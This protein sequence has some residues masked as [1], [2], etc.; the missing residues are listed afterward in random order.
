MLADA[1]DLAVG[2]LEQD[3]VVV[4]DADGRDALVEAGGFA[5]HVFDASHGHVPNYVMHAS[6]VSA[7]HHVVSR[8][9]GLHNA[10]RGY[11]DGKRAWQVASP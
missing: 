6:L 5:V 4:R 2:L 8:G 10:P 7:Q 1:D 11:L 9:L 3:L